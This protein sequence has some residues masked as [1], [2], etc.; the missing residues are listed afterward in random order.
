MRVFRGKVGSEGQ[1]MYVYEGLYKVV[2]AKQEESKDGPLVSPWVLLSLGFVMG[3]G[4]R[5]G[6]QNALSG[7]L[8]GFHRGGAG[9]GGGGK[10]NKQ[11]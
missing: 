7:C 8:W 1:R 9:R 5:R 6:R 2:E 3:P 4:K 10:A 11:N